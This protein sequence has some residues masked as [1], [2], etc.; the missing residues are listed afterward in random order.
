[1][2]EAYKL[3]LQPFFYVIFAYAMQPIVH[4]VYHLNER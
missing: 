2:A 1:M 4:K 3:R